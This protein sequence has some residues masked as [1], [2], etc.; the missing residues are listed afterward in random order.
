[1]LNDRGRSTVWCWNYI[2][3]YIWLSFFC[4]LSAKSFTTNG[5][6]RDCRVII[7]NYN[8]HACSTSISIALLWTCRY[9]H[10]NMM[11]L[12]LRLLPRV[13]TLYNNYCFWNGEFPA[14][15]HFL[16]Y[17]FHV[18]WKKFLNYR[19]DHKATV[20]SRIVARY[21]SNS[22]RER[23]LINVPMKQNGGTRTH[24]ARNREP[25]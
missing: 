8:T 2:S 18:K 20:L 4:V 1:M 9:S 12:I 6:T 7:T 25:N 17:H 14:C 10:N 3:E 23:P 24:C 22:V 19:R 15:P 11:I 13:W 5:V 16:V 21:F